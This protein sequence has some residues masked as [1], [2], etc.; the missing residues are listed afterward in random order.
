MEILREESDSACCVVFAINE[1]SVD[2]NSSCVVLIPT[3]TVSCDA[4]T[5]NSV[6]DRKLRSAQLVTELAADVDGADLQRPTRHDDRNRSSALR[7][8]ADAHAG[9]GQRIRRSRSERTMRGYARICGLPA[10]VER[11]CNTCAGG[12]TTSCAINPRRAAAPAEP[13]WPQ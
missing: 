7:Q 8:Q 2:A 6:F 10:P 11:R 12:Q 3:R 4:A 13:L 9:A 5:W 1:T